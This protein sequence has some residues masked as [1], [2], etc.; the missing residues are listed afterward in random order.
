MF[1]IYFSPSEINYH[2]QIF[3]KIPETKLW[4][5]K[6]LSNKTKTI[7][8]LLK[9]IEK[10]NSGKEKWCLS[11]NVHSTN[12]NYVELN[13]KLFPLDKKIKKKKTMWRWCMRV[14]FFRRFTYASHRYSNIL[15]RR[16]TIHDSS[17]YSFHFF[18]SMYSNI[19]VF[20]NIS[21]QYWE[22]V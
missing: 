16:I 22:M 1:T 4:R 14:F 21:D 11:N 2:F 10:T 18:S 20:N 8:N 17:L 19:N 9:N 5:K 12:W 6:K 13:K 3:K 7:T 15:K